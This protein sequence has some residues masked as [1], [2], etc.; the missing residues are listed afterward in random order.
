MEMNDQIVQHIMNTQ[1]QMMQSILKLQMEEKGVP[2]STPT[3]PQ[4][5]Q[6]LPP[7]EAGKPTGQWGFGT[8]VPA[9]GTARPSNIAST[10][11]PPATPAFPMAITN[12]SYGVANSFKSTDRQP[13]SS[14]GVTARGFIEGTIAEMRDFNAM[15]RSK[16]GTEQYITQQA[17]GL[18]E[19]A[20]NTTGGFVT[21]ATSAASMFLPM[22]FLPAAAIGA[23][24]GAVVGGTV[25]TMVDEAKSALD[26][27]DT[28]QQMD[29]KFINAFESSSDMGGIGMG[30]EDRQE[31]SRF[32]R[33][34][35]P[36]KFLEDS[37]INQI[38]TG[39]ADNNLLKSVR[40]VE[41]FK[42]KFSDIVDAVKEITVT[43]NATIE[44]A[45]AFMGEMERR[46]ITTQNM[47]MIA[48]QSKVT[49]SFTGKDVNATMEAVM[50]TSDAVTAGTAIDATKVMTG[51]NQGIFLSQLCLLYTSP[52]PRD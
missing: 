40:D 44:E 21:G 17:R 38:L 11:T 24:V 36:E 22:G 43:L 42:G 39:A 18:Q 14:F 35:G 30:L 8:E 34:V 13:A 41:S 12:P 9:F 51:T 20:L 15:G 32:L 33:E 4:T 47:G 26:F 19:Q 45:T 28:L 5:N 29:Y 49:S 48:A 50:S 23:G 37:E 25:N 27:Q 31:V 6:P 46:G 1:T 2:V 10:A 3:V 7:G 52:S 16:E